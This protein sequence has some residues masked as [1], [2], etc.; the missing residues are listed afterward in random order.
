MTEFYWIVRIGSLAGYATWYLWRRH[1]RTS[2][3]DVAEARLL[4]LVG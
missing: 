1:G 4:E 2:V 3:R